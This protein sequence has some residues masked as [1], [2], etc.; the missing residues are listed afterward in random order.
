MVG[1]KLPPLWLIE[2][3]GRDAKLIDWL[4]ELTAECPKEDCTQYERSM[5]CAVP[6]FGEGAL[7]RQLSRFFSVGGDRR[8]VRLLILGKLRQ[9]TP[10]LG[11]SLRKTLGCRIAGVLEATFRAFGPSSICFYRMHDPTDI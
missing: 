11:R 7:A 10:T 1:I 9:C 3:R 2:K 4:D 6:G 5:R 8:A